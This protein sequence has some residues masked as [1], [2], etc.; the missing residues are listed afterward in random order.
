MGDRTWI[1]YDCPKC[2]KKDGVEIY[3]TYSS[4]LYY[5]GCQYCDYKVDLS[6]YE[7]KENHLIL[8]S[9]PEAKKRGY[10]CKKCNLY[11]YPDERLLGVCEDCLKKEEENNEKN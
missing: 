1:F 5:E 11:L 8:L 3:D 10:L 4:F 6:Y 2:G 7:E 9:T